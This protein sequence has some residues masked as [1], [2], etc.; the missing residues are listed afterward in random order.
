ME[1]FL[2]GRSRFCQVKRKG[3]NI[4]DMC[5]RACSSMVCTL[6]NRRPPRAST[7]LP[8]GS[9]GFGLVCRRRL[10]GL[11]KWAWLSRSAP[12][13]TPPSKIKVEPRACGDFGTPSRSADQHLAH[14]ITGSPEPQHG[15]T[16]ADSRCIRLP[17]GNEKHAEAPVYRPRFL[18]GEPHPLAPSLSRTRFEVRKYG[19]KYGYASRNGIQLHMSVNPHHGPLKTAGCAYLYVEDADALHAGWSVV[20]GGGV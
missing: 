15:R 6:R 13:F 3:K 18:D 10:C 16:L 7:L 17:G 9:L 14:C 12:L 20:A 11:E 1:N 5:G 4:Y 19:D 2:W 8:S